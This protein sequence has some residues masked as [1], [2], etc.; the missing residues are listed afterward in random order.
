LVKVIGIIGVN[1]SANFYLPQLGRVLSIGHAR[2]LDSLRK[3]WF[4][5]KK[6]D[7]KNQG[8][9]HALL[10]PNLAHAEEY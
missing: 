1:I 4:R 7:K 10:L 9:K 6:K 8:E 2:I 5:P 3:R